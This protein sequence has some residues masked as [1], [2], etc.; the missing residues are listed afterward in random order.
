MKYESVY[1]RKPLCLFILSILLIQ[2]SSDRRSIELSWNQADGYRWSELQLPR[3]GKAGFN[4]LPESATGISVQNYLAEDSYINNSVLLNG[5]GVAAGDVNGN[6]LPDLYFTQIDGPNKLYINLG[7]FQFEDVSEKANVELNNYK[8]AGTLFADV[9]GDRHLDILVTTYHSGTILL[10]NNGNAEFTRAEQSGLDSTT[11]GGTTMTLADIDGD[12]DLDLY[13]THYI[14]ERVRDLYAPGE[15]AGSNVATLEGDRY[16]IREE[17]QKYYTNITSVAGPTLREKGTRDVLYINEGGIGDQWNGFQ[18]VENLEDHFLDENS[19]PLGVGEMWGLTARFEDITGDGL[20]DLYVCNDFWTPDQFWINQGDGV[21]KKIDPLKFRHMSLSSMGIAVGDV[22]NDGYSD[23]FISDM[24]SPVHTRR[25][26]QI[27]NL[28]PFPVE[29]G[30]VSNQPQYTHNTLYI[31]RGDNSFVETANYSG[32]DASGW[33]W[34]TSFIDADLDGLQDLFITTGYLYDA[35]DLD[36]NAQLGQFTD[37]QPYNLEG[38]LKGK[39]NYPPLNL[40]NRMYKNEGGLKFSDVGP[41]WGFLD[42][43]VSQGLA[44]AD[45]NND[46]SL[47]MVSSRMNNAAAIYENRSGN[48]RIAVRLVG[49]APNT[50]AIGA[51]VTLEGFEP[52]QLK[53]IVSGGNYMSGSAPHLMFATDTDSTSQSLH[54]TWPNGEVSTVNDVQANRIYEIYQD[55][56]AAQSEN[57]TDTPPH[58]TIFEDVSERLNIVDSENEYQDF[59]RQPLIPVMLSQLGPGASWIDINSDGREEFV[60]TSS[61]NGELAVFNNEGNGQF[62]KETIPGLT[63]QQN[64]DGDQTAVIGWQTEEQAH[65]VVGRSDYEMAASGGP[66]AYHYIIQN[67]QVVEAQELP[68]SNSSTGT[69]ATVDY[70]KNGT[71]DLFIGGRVIP[72]KYPASASS[73]LYNLVDNRFVEDE[74]NTDLLQEI[75]MVTGAVFT[76]YNNDSWPDLLISTEWGSLKLFENNEGQFR[77]VTEAVGLAEYKGLWNGLATGD[78]NGD[79]LPDIAATNWGTNSGYEIV[80]DYSMRI[81]HG[82]V[83]GNNTYDVIQANYSNEL[84]AYVPIRRLNFYSGFMPMYT[85]LNSYKD[86]ANLT[87]DGILGAMLEITPYEEVNTLHNMVFINSVDG[88]FEAQPLPLETQ[89]TAGISAN[90]GDYNNDGHEDLFIGQNFFDLPPGDTRLDGGIGLWLE[91]D[92]SG[93]FR[94]IPGQE[95]GVMVYG[96]QKGAALSDFNADGRVDLAVTQNGNQTKLYENRT[97]KRGYRIELIGPGSNR[98]A[99]GAKIRLEYDNGQ[100]GPQREIQAGSGYWSQ[101]SAIQILGYSDRADLQPAFIEVVWMDGNRKRIS[102]EQDKWDYVIS[103]AQ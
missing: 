70:N 44:I 65:I 30:E 11:V 88:Q 91:G 86:Y 25:M 17:F 47:D 93:Q 23:L 82:Y 43:D 3:N 96:E 75:G 78:F 36:S 19:D 39:L 53:R 64:Q 26:R 14:N 79:G 54:I 63:E 46:G 27:I 103:Y 49:S 22:N 101:N 71:L 20:P 34:A 62:T 31:N 18:K 4:Q 58:Q 69:L 50:Q 42:E 76:D 59:R 38:Y 51:E 94:A 45:L 95:S 72:G 74:T 10:L 97:E 102:I 90:V 6:G 56:I 89:L 16:N 41:N 21:F 55:S 1:L 92:G 68:G 8:S 40:R 84:D 85:N 73:A 48:D 37:R 66:S 80:E 67:G 60:Q 32:V 35:Q 61:Q 100:K 12:N 9:N 57:L 29:P 15:L 13:V 33:S 5:S 52:F 28:D 87:L 77:D 7:N 98:T 24:L 81:Y 99:I 83:D 2:C